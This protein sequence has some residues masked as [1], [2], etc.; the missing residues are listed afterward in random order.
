MAL[1]LKVWLEQE[2]VV[3]TMKFGQAMS[4]AE[5]T[6]EI[7][8]RTES[9][10]ADHGVFLPGDEEKGEPGIWLR[11]DK[12]LGF[13]DI[14]S[15]TTI[16]YKKKHRARKVRFLDDALKTRLLDESATVTELVEQIAE[17]EDIP[18]AEEFG[19][20][21]EGTERWLEA[22]KTLHENFVKDD[23]VVILARKFWFSD[24][25]CSLDSPKELHLLFV[26]AKG[27]VVRGILP[28]TR[29]QALDI[30]GLGLQI[31]F[32]NFDPE[33]VKTKGWFD[34]S[35]YMPKALYKKKKLL[36]DLEKDVAKEWKRK[37]GITELNAKYRFLQTCRSLPTWG[38]THWSVE[39]K[40]VSKKNAPPKWVPVRIGITR[41]T[42]LLLDIKTYEIL[43]E[44][45][46]VKIKRWSASDQSFTLDFGDWEDEYFTCKTRQGGEIAQ[47]L[48]GYID[49]ILKQR[50]QA[51]NVRPDD[52]AA[53]AKVTQ[54][55]VTR[56]HA[57]SARTGVTAK[58]TDMSATEGN[59]YDGEQQYGLIPGQSPNF[60]GMPGMDQ[61]L[62]DGLGIEGAAHITDLDSA[63]SGI[64]GF[65]SNLGTPL[66]GAALPQTM[67]I[68]DL[69][70]KFTESCSSA[71]RAA[72]GLL[73][74]A[75]RGRLDPN[76]LNDQAKKMAFDVGAA[77]ASAK[78]AAATD[79][80]DIS[81]LPGAYAIS[82]AISK[83]LQVSRDLADGS[84][85]DPQMA[86]W[87]SQ[88]AFKAAEMVMACAQQGYLSDTASKDLILESARCVAEA[89]QNLKAYS[90]QGAG[91]DADL[92]RVGRNVG[93]YLSPLFL[94]SLLLFFFVFFLSFF[95]FSY[96]EI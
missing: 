79:D 80:Q 11:A 30:G 45:P 43:K 74:T 90:D 39:E 67:V 72:L 17:G 20:Q 33:K 26:Q 48:A 91:T 25:N 86:V 82:E 3:K 64:D 7:R 59:M 38:V 93:L 50:R 63:I 78:L 14:M 42:I 83:V 41:K 23:D 24:A 61:E 44:W 57:A 10:G 76:F 69:R 9:G 4:I 89:A 34:P 51:P 27:M 87:I 54:T 75:A 31:R 65:L 60:F 55:A 12:T 18:N 88:Q 22:P 19:L 56:G 40:V 32:G 58:G 68:S 92:Q 37:V 70:Q 2:N 28:V 81:L 21:V 77:I 8:E 36:P 53:V 1:S 15:H 16:H 85:A 6:K 96:L 71:Q 49:I 35:E 52:D 62:V 29:D 84:E 94:L 73:D 5:V 46:I 95:F 13:Y 66:Q 47:Q